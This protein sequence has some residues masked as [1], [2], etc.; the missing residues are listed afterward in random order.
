MSD[1]DDTR[2]RG[3]MGVALLAA[4]CLALSV[5]RVQ[6]APD[7][8]KENEV[9]AAFLYNF[10]QFVEWPPEV[11]PDAEAPF[12]LGVLG[13]DQFAD[14]LEQTVKNE[15]VKGRPLLVRKLHDTAGLAGCHVLFVSRSEDARVQT[16]LSLLDKAGVLTVGECAG[17]A[18]R[19][20]AFN[21]FL[22]GNKIRFEINQEAARR[23]GLK[24]SAQLMSLGKL[25]ESSPIKR[26]R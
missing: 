12:I 18:A 1:K 11:F 22:Q 14:T 7:T 26:E 16:V 15:K 13:N 23:K 5:T 4:C 6:A 25:V 24:I 9:K 10:T 20:G 2:N 3:A 21:F 17:F 8:F 19:G